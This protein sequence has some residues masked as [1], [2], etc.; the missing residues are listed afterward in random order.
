MRGEIIHYDESQGFGF[1]SG[2]DGN[3]YTFRREDL[4]RETYLGKGT[5]VEFEASDGQARNVFSIRA[6][7]G[8]VPITGPTGPQPHASAPQPYGR[9]PTYGA[10]T[11]T[12]LWDYFRNAYTLNYANFSGR[13]RRKEYWGFMLFW[14]LFAIGLTIAAMA[15]DG[16]LGNM[17]GDEFPYVTM[18]V[19]GIWFLG[20]LVPHLSITIRRQHDIGLSGWFYLLIL[21]PYIGGIIIFVFT[22]I[23]TQMHENK[24]GPIPEG[25][26]LPPTYVPNAS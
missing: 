15:V 19:L 20:S 17:D 11:G 12:G 14:Y 18:V 2:S 21:I 1:I 5:Q 23:P 7:A 26:P 10:P 9:N 4:R 25:I 6:Q 13:A 8:S 24:W 22:L 16:V 3:R